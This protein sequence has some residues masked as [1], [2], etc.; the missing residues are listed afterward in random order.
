MTPILR[1]LL[2][3]R[4]LLV[5]VFVTHGLGKISGFDAF[6]DKFQ[7]STTLIVLLTISELAGAIGMLL[8]ALP[9]EPWACWATRLAA[10]SIAIGQI[11]AIVTVRWPNW[12]EQYYGMEYNVVLLGLC[13]I[14][15]VG[16]RPPPRRRRDNTRRRAPARTSTPADRPR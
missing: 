13:L 5:V 6:Q 12:F 15:V 14:L 7:L 2:I 4:A 16:H 8:G 10:L 3:P 9:I 11:G 1:L